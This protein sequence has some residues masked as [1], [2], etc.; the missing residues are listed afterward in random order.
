MYVILT[1]D[2]GIPCLQSIRDVNHCEGTV[3]LAHHIVCK[4]NNTQS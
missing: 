2:L 3:R 1:S 4:Y